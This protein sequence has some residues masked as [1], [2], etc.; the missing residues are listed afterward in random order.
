MATK[1]QYEFFKLLYD[2]E[3]TRFAALID[4]GKTILSLSVLYT[5]FLAF[6]TE[7]NKPV[8]VEMY[9]L[10]VLTVVALLTALLLA[11]LALGIYK[12]EGLNDPERVVSQFGREAPA[13]ESFFEDRIADCVVACT[14]NSNKNNRR[15]NLLFGSLAVLLAGLFLHAVYFF[16]TLYPAT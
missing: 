9:I 1:E 15:A 13:N 14:R 8:S 11:I 5:A 10:F 2:E 3:N 16:V 7:K 4:R 6:S 12:H